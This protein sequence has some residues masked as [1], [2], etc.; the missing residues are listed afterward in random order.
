MQA[1]EVAHAAAK[2]MKDVTAQITTEAFANHS[3]QYKELM[4]MA[5]TSPR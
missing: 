5:T 3:L 1:G 2:Y 4:M